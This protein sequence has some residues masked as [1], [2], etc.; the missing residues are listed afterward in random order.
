LGINTEI[1]KVE[2]LDKITAYS[3]KMIPALVIDG[4][5]RVAGRISSKQEITKWVEE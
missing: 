4:E 3:V 1:V 5:V 2:D